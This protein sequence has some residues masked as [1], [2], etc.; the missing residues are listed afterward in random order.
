MI[1][2]HWNPNHDKKIVHVDGCPAEVDVNYIVEAGVIGDIADAMAR[3]GAQC[4]RDPRS[5]DEK[6]SKKD[7]Q[8]TEPAC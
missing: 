7:H 3:I 1:R 4:E 5:G 6:P 8:R 2:A